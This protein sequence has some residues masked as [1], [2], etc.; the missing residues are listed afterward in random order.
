MEVAFQHQQFTGIY[1]VSGHFDQ[2]CGISICYIWLKWDIYIYITYIQPSDYLGIHAYI[3]VYTYR[4]CGVFAS[5]TATSS[6]VSHCMVYSFATS[7]HL[8]IHE[9]QGPRYHVQL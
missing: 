6:Y 7:Y 9:P 5:G 8:L 4:V 1:G 2:T 3:P